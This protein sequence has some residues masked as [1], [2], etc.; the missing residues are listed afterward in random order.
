MGLLLCSSPFPATQLVKMK[1]MTAALLLGALFLL[2]AAHARETKWCAEQ[3]EQC[4]D[5]CPKDSK[6]DFKC[7][8]SDGEPRAWGGRRRDPPPP[9]AAAPPPA[10]PAPTGWPSPSHPCRRPQRCLRLRVTRWQELYE[11]YQFLFHL[12]LLFL[13][14]WRRLERQHP[15][16]RRPGCRPGRCLNRQPRPSPARPTTHPI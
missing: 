14:L 8:D 5:N 7:R 2:S 15:H 12:F 11:Q 10:P 1:A 4:E 6:V 13:Q 3:R 9:L 16:R